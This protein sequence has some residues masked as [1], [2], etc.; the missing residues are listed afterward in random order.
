[1]SFTIGLFSL[2]LMILLQWGLY[3]ALTKTSFQPRVMYGIGIFIS[4][5]F[6]ANTNY[7][8]LAIPIKVISLYLCWN[9]LIFSLSYGNYLSVQ[10]EYI[11]FRMENVINYLS[12][13][14]EE[15]CE[16][17]YLMIYG[18]V[19]VAPS[20][21]NIGNSMGEILNRINGCGFYSGDIWGYYKFCN[22]YKLKFDL[23]R[24][25]EVPEEKWFCD[26]YLIDSTMY[27]D[28]YSIEGGNAIVIR[29]L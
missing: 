28:V 27:F 4:L 2:I 22:N 6:V 21:E 5:I 15:N 26:D 20:L 16:S 12:Y 19:G 18:G 10:K 14:Q 7:L 25:G 24:M 3:P 8:T 17:K 13:M 23:S 11:D 1:M 9:F 29:L